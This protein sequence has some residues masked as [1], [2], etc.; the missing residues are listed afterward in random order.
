MGA[1]GV[2]ESQMESVGALPSWSE[3]GAVATGGAA[4]LAFPPIAFGALGDLVAPSQT[5][6]RDVHERFDHRVLDFSECQRQLVFK[7]VVLFFGLSVTKKWIGLVVCGGPLQFLL[8]ECSLLRS[9][10]VPRMIVC[11]DTTLRPQRRLIGNF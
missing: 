5:L 7:K 3:R 11:V 6:G 1:L 10:H 9:E 4:P 2:L 8:F